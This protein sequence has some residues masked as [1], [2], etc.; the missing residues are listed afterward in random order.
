MSDVRSLPYRLSKCLEHDL[1]SRAV[2]MTGEPLF[3]GSLRDQT[4]KAWINGDSRPDAEVTE[5]IANVLGV[6]PAWL[7]FG[8]GTTAPAPDWWKEGK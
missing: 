6:D 8:S 2:Q 1:N 3:V 7:A 4:L 5:I